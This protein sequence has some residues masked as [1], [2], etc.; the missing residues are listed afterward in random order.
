MGK[1]ELVKFG[2][3]ED[4]GIK[5]TKDMF[6]SSKLMADIGKYITVSFEDGITWTLQLRVKEMKTI[7]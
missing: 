5:F 6:D 2:I 1:R 3:R 7:L 4:D